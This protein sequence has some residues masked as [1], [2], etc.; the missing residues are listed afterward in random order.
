MIAHSTR[1]RSI[2]QLTSYAVSYTHL[3]GLAGLGA[4]V[5]TDIPDRIR[6]GYGLNR[7]PVSY[8]HLNRKKNR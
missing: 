1:L 4:D 7:N 6:D 5:D 3:E 2:S 8:T